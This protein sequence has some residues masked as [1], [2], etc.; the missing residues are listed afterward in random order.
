MFLDGGTWYSNIKLFLIPGKIETAGWVS[1]ASHL[2]P[3]YPHSC[4]PWM[5]PGPKSLLPFDFSPCRQ[6]SARHTSY[7]QWFVA[8]TL[9]PEC[10]GIWGHN[11][12]VS[13]VATV[14]PQKG[15]YQGSLAGTS[16][17]QCHPPKTSVPQLSVCLTTTTLRGSVIL[18]QFHLL[19]LLHPV[20][21][22]TPAI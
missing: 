16:S 14:W 18:F 13:L 1:T 22:C 11:E 17:E 8:N 5:A 3:G 20:F 2:A 21:K 9:G 19:V 10:H 15:L 12:L 4:F 6:L 7:T